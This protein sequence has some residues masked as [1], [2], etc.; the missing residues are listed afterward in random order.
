[1]PYT[2]EDGSLFEMGCFGLCAC[3]IVDAP[4]RGT[5]DLR[6]IGYDGLFDHY[7]VENVQ[8]VIGAKDPIA[9]V[10]GSGEYQVGGEF[11]LQQQLTLDLSVNGGAKQHFDS[12]RVSGGGEFPKI[13]IASS[14]HQMKSCYDSVFVVKASPDVADVEPVTFG[15]SPVA[16]N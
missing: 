9:R 15:L 16:P 5:F 10:V 4:L 1:R 12:G 11:A 8:W 2:L 14:L 6:H 13:D 7:A 3:P